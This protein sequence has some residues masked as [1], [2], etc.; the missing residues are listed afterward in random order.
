MKPYLKF[1]FESTNAHGVHSPFVYD[2]LAKCFYAKEAL[3]YNKDYYKRYGSQGR[4]K[5]ELLYRLVHYFRPAKLLVLGEEASVIT[6]TLRFAGESIN[7]RV[8]FF[9]TLAPV[10]G[11]IDLGYISHNDS[12]IALQMFEEIVAAANNNSVCIIGNIHSSVEMEELWEIIKVHPKVTVTVDTYH[13]GLVF[14]RKE[15]R[16]QH[17]IVR[18][19]QSILLNA[20]LGAR[21]LY[22]LLD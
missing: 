4:K 12:G 14:F 2:L 17:F 13:L 18:L 19:S 9:S 8:W 1:L 11:G 3:P 16:N 6:D 22:G 10:P 20:V 21:K 15:Q 7:L 5:I